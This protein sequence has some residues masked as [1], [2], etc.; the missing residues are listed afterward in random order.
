MNGPFK[1]VKYGTNIVV[2]DG[3]DFMICEVW[4]ENVG[5]K[6][7]DSLNKTYPTVEKT[8]IDGFDDF[9]TKVSCEEFYNA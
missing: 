5:E 9:D 3:S 7:V 6:I 2:T 1:V 4:N 8:H